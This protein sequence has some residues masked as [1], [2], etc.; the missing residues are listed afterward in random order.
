MTRFREMTPVPSL[1][2]VAWRTAVVI[3]AESKPVD[4]D[5]VAREKDNKI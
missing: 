4:V 5:E 2:V 1:V 3:S